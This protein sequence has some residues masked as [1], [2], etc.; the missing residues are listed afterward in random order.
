MAKQKKVKRYLTGKV[1]IKATFAQR[2][3]PEEAKQKVRGPRQIGQAKSTKVVHIGKVD[4]Q[5]LTERLALAEKV[6]VT[7]KAPK[8]AT[9]AEKERIVALLADNKELQELMAKD[10]KEIAELKGEIDE[11]AE[12]L[13]DALKAIKSGTLEVEKLQAQVDELSGPN[14]EV[15]DEK[16]KTEKPKP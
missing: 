11:A 16:P 5:D 8:A 1:E 10:A 12:T 9:S 15:P 6:L 2:R 3:D 13:E 4:H 14:E 7:G